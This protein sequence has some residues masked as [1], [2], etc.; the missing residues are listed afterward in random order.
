MEISILNILLIAP[1][2]EFSLDPQINL[3][4]QST[5]SLSKLL[6]DKRIV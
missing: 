4:G 6:G 3:L 2:L 5:P 1:E